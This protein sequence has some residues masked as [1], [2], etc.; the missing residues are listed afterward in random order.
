MRRLALTITLACV[1]SGAA[2]AGEMPS[3]GAPTPPP[4]STTTAA[5]EIPTT[6]SAAPGEIHST[7]APQESDTVL[8]IIL[9]IIGFVR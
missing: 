2:H 3:T 6:G 8:T 4:P 1:L 5:G 9:T 7:G